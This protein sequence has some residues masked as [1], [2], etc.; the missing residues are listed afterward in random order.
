MTYRRSFVDIAALGWAPEQPCRESSR[1]ENKTH[2]SQPGRIQPPKTPSRGCGQ[3]DRR[4]ARWASGL[5]PVRYVKLAELKKRC[6]P[7]F[8]AS[9]IR[10]RTLPARLKALLRN[11]LHYILSTAE[12][13]A[14]SIN[15][16]EPPATL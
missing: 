14:G 15:F 12:A 6:L 3:H 2:E 13:K 16:T 9:S 7:N 4:A 1:E 8:L 11:N 10:A 5:V